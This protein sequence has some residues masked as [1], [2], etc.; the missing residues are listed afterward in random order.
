MATIGK[1]TTGGD[2]YYGN[3]SRYTLLAQIAGP[4][5]STGTADYIKARIS[6]R[7]SNGVH[8]CYLFS[9]TGVLIAATENTYLYTT[10]NYAWVQFNFADPKPSIISGNSYYLGISTITN[11]NRFVGELWG[12]PQG[13]YFQSGWDWV[14]PINI[15]LALTQPS[16][17]YHSI[18]LSYTEGITGPTITIE[19]ITP[20]SIEGV[21]WSDVEDVY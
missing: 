10:Y 19:G 2:S 17:A 7:G 3:Y 5:A 16:S 9:S 12:E 8:T 15:N 14:S 21:D 6:P 4:A 11:N 13:I 18:Y 1:T 20:G